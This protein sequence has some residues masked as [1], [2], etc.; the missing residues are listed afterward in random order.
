[1][2]GKGHPEEKR[3]PR[4][5]K[6]ENPLSLPRVDTSSKRKGKKKKGGTVSWYGECI[7]KG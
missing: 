6:R 4:S 3:I 1:M 2:E 5:N 7:D